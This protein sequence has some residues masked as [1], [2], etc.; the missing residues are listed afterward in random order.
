VSTWS[1]AD[2]QAVAAPEEVEV[3]T[4]RRDGSLRRPMTIWIV[5]VGDRVFIRS[6]NGRSADWFRGAL[7]TGTGQVV[8]AGTAH[9]VRF[10]EA[11][12]SALDAVD[13]AYRA[14]YGSYRS[15][16]DHLNGAGPRAATLQVIPA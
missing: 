9:R 12:E 13:A 11:D 3:I 6:T 15:I 8:A 2:A 5:G 1:H 7:A 14:K 4:A 10:V 16:V